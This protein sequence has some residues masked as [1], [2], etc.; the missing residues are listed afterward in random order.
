M[1]PCPC[2]ELRIDDACDLELLVVASAWHIAV[3]AE[4]G[5]GSSGAAKGDLVPEHMSDWAVAA[6]VVSCRG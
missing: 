3:A 2:W 4:E 6:G 1:D 5:I